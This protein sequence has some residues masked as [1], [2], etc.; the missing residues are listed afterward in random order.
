M[1]N[2]FLKTFILI[3]IN[4]S[5]L[6]FADSQK[7]YVIPVDST[8]KKIHF[9]VVF[10]P[11]KRDKTYDL[12]SD[13][14]GGQTLHLLPHEISKT[15]E[16]LQFGLDAD[17]LLVS[18]SFSGNAPRESFL[19]APNGK[20]IT[21]SDSNVKDLNIKVVEWS[22]GRAITITDPAPGNWK[23]LIS[24]VGDF[25]ASVKAKSEIY[26]I[27]TRFV[28][29]GGRPGHE[30]LFPIKEPPAINAQQILK[31]S[32]SEDTGKQAPP[33][34]S[35]IG[36]NARMLANTKVIAESRGSMADFYGVVTIPSQGFRFL[37]SGIDQN[38][39]KYQ[40]VTT[41]VTEPQQK[42]SPNSEAE[43]K[44]FLELSSARITR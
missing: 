3:I 36:E 30:G 18:D 13:K 35:L 34:F 15:S 25:S 26:F 20:K 17:I 5:S 29:K 10:K 7:E 16:I 32:F 9:V 23:L 22:R 40:R 11:E 8:I 41:A 2:F 28:K 12:I 27:N 43:I 42:P 1:R 6:V 38:G 21:A 19:F 24:G 44:E 4:F 31:V 39:F 37:A 14:T 33:Q